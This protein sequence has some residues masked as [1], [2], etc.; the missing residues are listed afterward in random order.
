MI[1]ALYA[2]ALVAAALAVVLARRNPEH[3][4]VAAFLILS[5]A[6]DVVRNRLIAWVL[7][8]ARAALGSAPFTGWVRVAADVDGAL[9]VAWR[10]GIAALAVWMFVRRRP[11]GVLAAYAAAVGFMVATYPRGA[12][13][14]RFYLATELASLCVALGGFLVW[15]RSDRKT[16]VPA[17][18]TAVIVAIELA[19]VTGG[20]YRADI[21]TGWISA[22]NMLVVLYLALIVVQGVAVW[23]P[24]TSQ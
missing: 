22:Q 1:A 10:A 4:P 20:P 5:L 18:C 8:P 16:T 3:R 21:F 24:S 7:Q 14:H 17:V 15:L 23:R 9:F 12:V 13:L 11:W 2:L 19:F 6:S